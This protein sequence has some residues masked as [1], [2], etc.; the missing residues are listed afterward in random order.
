VF[1]FS[2][3][4]CFGLYN[5]VAYFVYYTFAFVVLYL[6]VGELCCG[7]DWCCFDAVVLLVDL[8]L[9]YVYDLFDVWWLDG[10]FGFVF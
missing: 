1:V 5:S 8:W 7:F 4:F 10:V 6:F 3:G 2:F 9:F